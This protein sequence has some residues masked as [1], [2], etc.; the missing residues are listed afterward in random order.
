MTQKDLLEFRLIPQTCKSYLKALED[1]FLTIKQ[2]EDEVLNPRKRLDKRRDEYK[3]YFEELE[4]LEDLSEKDLEHLPI[5]EKTK[6]LVS[7]YFYFN[8]IIVYFISV[9][10]A[11]NDDLLEKVSAAF[12]NLNYD[13][14]QVNLIKK[15][16][17]FLP[18]ILKYFSEIC[19]LKEFYHRRNSIVHNNGKADQ[20]YYVKSKAL[21]K[22]LNLKPIID[23]KTHEFLTKYKDIEYLY[24]TLES[25]I[26]TLYEKTLDYVR[27]NK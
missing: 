16:D 1:K 12:S 27:K 4:F 18:N 17:S 19:I 23:S 14:Q 20:N 21:L 13:I 9:W 3:E 8:M 10:E 2:I 6:E 22:H 26:K 5:Y 15:L 7:S 11:F 25:Y 24:E